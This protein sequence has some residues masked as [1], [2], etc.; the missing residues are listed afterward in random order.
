MM[1]LYHS[2]ARLI[3]FLDA[4]NVIRFVGVG[5]LSFV[6]DVL[7]LV[8]FQEMGMKR[9]DNGFLVSAAA[10]FIISLIVHYFMSAKWVFADNEIKTARDHAVAGVLFAVTNVVGLLLNEFL[11]WIGVAL[12]GVHYIIV[13]IVAAGVV[14]V[15]NY[16]C[17]RLL[18]FRKVV[19]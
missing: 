6:I 2:I 1:K 11:M 8:S 19:N 3:A 14:M 17:Q 9:I 16:F 12:L 5:G 13:K 10:G 15:W 7:V 18:V 4:N